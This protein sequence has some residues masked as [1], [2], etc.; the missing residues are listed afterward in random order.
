MEK[1]DTLLNERED[2]VRN[3]ASTAL[4]INYKG[5]SYEPYKSVCA[6]PAEAAQF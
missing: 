2:I 5:V 1:F 4:Y 6:I 3:H